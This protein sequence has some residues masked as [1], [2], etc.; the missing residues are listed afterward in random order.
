MGNKHYRLNLG[1]MQCADCETVI[2][3]AVLALPGVLKA[4]ADF[5]EER[6][7][8]VIDTRV[9]A[10][11]TVCAA[12]KRAGYACEAKPKQ[13]PETRSRG[14]WA[15][16]GAA[17]IA[18]LLALDRHLE[19][20][21]ALAQIDEHADYG[22]LFLIGMFTS[23]HCVGMCGGFVLGYTVAGSQQGR[24]SHRQHLLYGLGKLVSYTSFGGL[25]GWIGGGISF[26]DSLRSGVLIAAGVF[27]LV[28]GLGM[29]DFFHGLRRFQI[30][31]PRSLAHALAK[32]RQHTSSPLAIGLLN[33]L[34][35]ACGPLQAMYILAAGTGSPA[36]GAAFLAVFALGTLPMMFAFGYLANL[37][38]ANTTRVFMKLSSLIIVA[39]GLMMLDRG[40]LLA[41]GG[42]DARSLGAKAM[43]SIETQFAA[44]QRGL[45]AAGAPMQEGYQVI[46][47]EVEAHTFTPAEHVLHNRVPV[48]WIINVK[49]LS[50]CNRQI[51]VPALSLVIDLKPGLQLVE[52]T[53]Q[54]T[55]VIG[56]S[57]YMGMIAGTF[58][59]KD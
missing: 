45:I 39:L 13:P 27:L 36:K 59:V 54:E 1:D 48:K 19:F 5:T 11:N 14:W 12:I 24:P 53:P 37:V 9:I 38:T 32:Q 51:I 20:D 58:M 4:Q 34:M 8:L 23:F 44:W 46:Y 30:R 55:G 35:I 2:E 50:A 41:G 52:F 40:L 43:L 56:W 10:L 29:L 49:Q 16:L 25:F 26:N 7:E 21:A 18:L 33:G 15:W 6:L 28:Y 31:L 42:W 47:T 22:L 57:C 3:E 17:G